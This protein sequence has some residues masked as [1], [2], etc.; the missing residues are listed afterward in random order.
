MAFVVNIYVIWPKK[1]VGVTYISLKVAS[2]IFSFQCHVLV[3][4]MQMEIS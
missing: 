1:G 4:G 3:G 2:K